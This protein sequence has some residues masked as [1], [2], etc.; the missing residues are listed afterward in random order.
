MEDGRHEAAEGRH[1]KRKTAVISAARGLPAYG[2]TLWSIAATRRRLMLVE[3]ENQRPNPLKAGAGCRPFAR[4][5][6]ASVPLSAF[7]R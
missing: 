3:G 7:A 1:R 4:R 5:A 2:N 6:P